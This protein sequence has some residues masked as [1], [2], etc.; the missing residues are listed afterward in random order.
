MT[1]LSE[2]PM[3]QSRTHAWAEAAM[4]DWVNGRMD[5][6]SADRMRAHLA[7]CAVC[8]ADALIEEQVQARLS[9]QPVVEYAPQASFRRLM[10]QIHAG[11]PPDSDASADTK[12][13]RPRARPWL[14]RVAAVAAT[15]LVTGLWI[16]LAWSPAPEYRTLTNTPAVENSLR[17]QVVFAEGATAGDI[18][19]ALGEVNG[20][21]IDG[22]GPSGLF[23]VTL[24]SADA[25]ASVADWQAAEQRLQQHP[26]VRFVALVGEAGAP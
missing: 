9:R 16:Q 18:R 1:R 21:M 6:T 2:D 14:S 12:T 20:Q 19:A 25:E 17:L 11:E 7:Q 10:D 15:V 24:A 3:E 23:T 13:P 26:S 22:P 5:A 8:R 4:T